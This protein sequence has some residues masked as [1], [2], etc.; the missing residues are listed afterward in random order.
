M[1]VEHRGA[2]APS[3]FLDVSIDVPPGITILFGPSGA[4]KSTLLDCIAGL[5]RP[6]AGRIASGGDVLFDSESDV[7]LPPQKRQIAY[8]FQS[9]AL[10]PH[11]TRGTKCR[12]WPGAICGEHSNVTRAGEIM[13]V[14][15][16]ESSASGSRGEISGG[17]KQRIALATI[18]GDL[19]ASSA[20]RRAADGTGRRVESVDRRRFARL[21][22]G[23]KNS[24]SL[25]DP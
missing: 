18:A 11:M 10:F 17:E 12:L 3:F 24:D 8:V 19:A 6:D 25:R 9:L 5:L 2:D 21:E 1:R 13:E 14:F 16:V 7:N 22:C 20:A 23:A 4:G 15:R